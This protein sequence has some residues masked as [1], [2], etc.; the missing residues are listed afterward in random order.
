MHGYDIM[1]CRFWVNPVTYAALN[2]YLLLGALCAF[3]GFVIDKDLTGHTVLGLFG[4]IVYIV[5]W[6]PIGIFGIIRRN[7]KEWYHTEHTG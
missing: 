4:F 1:L 7:K 6:I 3:A 2:I 5:T